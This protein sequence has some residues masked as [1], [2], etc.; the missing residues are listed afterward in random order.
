[1][2]CFMPKPSQS[3]FVNHIQNKEKIYT[4]KELYKEKWEWRIKE[5]AKRKLFNCSRYGD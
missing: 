1:M 2:T 3:F 4:E 5:K